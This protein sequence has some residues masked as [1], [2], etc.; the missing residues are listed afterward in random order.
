MTEIIIYTTDT[1][2]KCRDNAATVSA[3]RLPGVT[4]AQTQVSGMVTTQVPKT[5]IMGLHYA[6]TTW[7]M[8]H[9]A[10]KQGI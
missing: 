4:C 8:E 9:T 6:G 2:P 7:D 5:T 3:P 10:T 1:C